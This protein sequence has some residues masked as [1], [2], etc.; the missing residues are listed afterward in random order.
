MIYLRKH[1]KLILGFA[2]F[3]FSFLLSPVGNTTGKKPNIVVFFYESVFQTIKL[4]P[5]LTCCLRTLS[6]VRS[7]MALQNKTLQW[8]TLNPLHLFLFCAKY[9]SVCSCPNV[10]YQSIH[11]SCSSHFQQFHAVVGGPSACAL[12]LSQQLQVGLSLQGSGGEG[13]SEGSRRDEG[14]APSL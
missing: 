8:Q 9:C 12:Y 7:G 10:T 3:C 6:A 4:I 11:L 5:M 13:D 1:D 14:K 2:L